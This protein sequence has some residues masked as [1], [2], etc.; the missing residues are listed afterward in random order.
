MAQ[1]IGLSANP[2]TLIEDEGTL[3]TLTINLSEAPPAGGLIV[4]LTSDMINSLGEFD[5]F[6]AQFSGVQITGVSDNTDGFTLRITSQTATISLPVFPDN[7]TE[8]AETITFSLQAGNGFAIDP[9]AAAVAVTIQ[10]TATPSPSPSPSPTPT[11]PPS[12]GLPLV[13]LNTGPNYLIESEGT[14]SAHVFNITGGTIPA[15]GL[16]VSV[17]TPN[18][19]EF[20]L[21]KIKISEGG[22]IVA[23]REDGFDI[24][25]T[26]F[27]VLVDL[28]VAADGE[29][30]GLETA[31][32]TLQTGDGYEVNSVLSNGEF[33][34]VDTAEEVPAT[35]LNKLND[36]LPLA[37]ETGLSESNSVYQV[38]SSLDFNIGNRYLNEDGTYSYVDAS[39]DVDFYA[40]ELKAGNIISIDIDAAQRG[41]PPTN[42]NGYSNDGVGPY[43]SQRIFDAEGNELAAN[44]QANGH[45]ELFANFDGYQ[46]FVA[47]ADGTYYIG[48]S[49]VDS[50]LPKER[51]EVLNTGGGR[52]IYD[53]FVP[54]SGDNSG[55]PEF[56]FPVYGEYDM[57]ITLNPE[58]ILELP[59]FVGDNVGGGNPSDGDTPQPGT[60]VVSLDFLATTF[61]PETG[62]LIA[63]YLVEGLPSTDSALILTFKVE[64]DIPEEGILVNVNSDNYLRQYISQRSFQALPFTPGAALETILYDET[65][66]ETGFQFRISEPYTSIGFGAQSAGWADVIDPDSDQPEEVTWFIAPGEGYTVD[67]NAGEITATY[68][69]VDQTPELTVV[70]EVGITISETQLLESEQTVAT[71]TFTLSEPPPPEGV[72]VQV[73]GS[74]EGILQ[75]F[76]IFNLELEG[77]TFPYPTE[78]FTGFLFKIT[79]QQATITIPVF[80]DPFEEGLQGFSFALAEAS[81]YTVDPNAREAAFTIADNPDSIA[82]VSLSSASPTLVES[83]NAAGVLTFNLTANPP[84]EGITATVDA[85]NLSEFDVD[86]LTVTGGEITEIT[87]SGFTL[88]ITDATATVELPALADGTAEGIETAT[89]KLI[90]SEGATINPDTN[91]A[92]LTLVDNPAQVPVTQ[93]FDSND[94]IAQALDLNLNP[95]NLST[96]VRGRI[97][98]EEPGEGF[99]PGFGA[100]A[101]SD[102]SEDVDFYSVELNAGDTVKIDV[103][104]VGSFTTLLHPGVEQRL[105]SE[106]RL[107]DANGNE[108]A[109]VNN[110]AAPGEE[111]SRDP[112]LEFTASEAGTYYVGVSQLG[113]R[114][115]D[116][117]VE[118]S[119]SGWIFPE[120]GVHVGEYD[121]NVGVTA[122]TNPPTPDTVTL[123]ALDAYYTYEGNISARSNVRLLADKANVIGFPGRET[124][125]FLQFDP[126]SLPTDLLDQ[127]FTVT[128]TLQ[129]DSSLASTLIPATDDRPVSLSV[130]DLTAPF[131]DTQ[132][133]GNIADIAYGENGANTVDTIEVGNDGLYNWDITTLIQQWAIDPT[134]NDGLAISGFYGNVDTDGR[135]SY[136]IFH[137]VGSTTGQVPILTLNLLGG[138]S[139]SPETLYGTDAAETLAGGQVNDTLYG[140]G[141]EDFLNGRAGDDLIYGGSQM[142]TVLGGAGDDIIYANGSGDLINA[143]TG[144]DTVWLGA[145]A[146]AVVLNAGEGYVTVKNFQLG[147]TQFKGAG[148][149]LSF[150]DSA[151]GVKISKGDDLL[152]VATWQTAS[153][154]SQNA[155]AIFA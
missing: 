2:T 138:G 84:A 114:S 145:G 28:P 131:N 52:F 62:D 153:T 9:A 32:F 95:E 103:D 49:G 18:L 118:N 41:E 56:D 113:N 73:D 17:K 154:F 22:E 135:N 83:E 126:A 75:Q 130:Y 4:T 142:D 14:V 70:P 19:S 24:R 30:E 144:M 121:L 87:D 109:S 86:A 50:G 124:F 101:L 79:E 3:T 105:D 92:T 31:S 140:N 91:E 33:T 67:S 43:I 61:D 106:L 132:P 25:L 85:P 64:G 137:T 89:F 143:G 34:L 47:P 88:K 98:S 82:E 120:I 123:P 27:T 139:D 44:W 53:P 20:D 112:Y 12:S 59:Q 108:L 74:G 46:E 21:S 104:A 38:T 119:G 37:V 99:I 45:R 147:E 141:G 7:E 36:A 115:Y 77:G 127:E 151:D 55:F 122:A 60:P 102:F 148:S 117:N 5:V 72:V 100:L 97:S 10:D 29:A 149:G 116:P 54:G 40:V 107:F 78:D 23:V 94:T 155:A 125:S 133:G 96:T 13:S 71:I 69:D 16:V 57:T 110:A 93:E 51:N 8:G 11:P 146:A 150:S 128:L 65:Q 66:R 35:A 63:P 111:L 129:Q 136:G 80:Q 76:G 1:V 134:N 39:E 81:H 58:V 26:D 15:G 68:Y 6:A 90:D 42:L 152:A 48:L